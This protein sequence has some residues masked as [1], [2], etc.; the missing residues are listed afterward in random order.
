M[1][2]DLAAFKIGNMKAFCHGKFAL[3]IAPAKDRSTIVASFL[4][5]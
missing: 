2:C 5:P 4:M 3:A 1:I